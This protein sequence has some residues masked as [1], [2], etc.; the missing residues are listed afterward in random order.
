MR[1]LSQLEILNSEI[2]VSQGGRI[3]ALWPM[4][5]LGSH[6]ACYAS[7][8]SGARTITTDAADSLLRQP[9]SKHHQSSQQRMDENHI[10]TIIYRCCLLFC[11]LQNCQVPAGN[12]TVEYIFVEVRSMSGDTFSLLDSF[13][14]FAM[15]RV[16]Q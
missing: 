10:E 15:I 3:D 5:P 16:E 4:P 7:A 14:C 11:L 13:V 8:D 6:R 9:L 2:V 12:I 1:V